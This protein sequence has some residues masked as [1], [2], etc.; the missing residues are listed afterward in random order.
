MFD[1]VN[2]GPQVV[3]VIEE[4]YLPGFFQSSIFEEVLLTLGSDETVQVKSCMS[5]HE[6]ARTLEH[7]IR[8]KMHEWACSDSHRASNMGHTLTSR[9]ARA[10]LCRG[11]SCLIS[12]TQKG[13]HERARHRQWVRID[14][15]VPLSAETGGRACACVHARALASIWEHTCTPAHTHQ[16]LHAPPLPNIF[17][18]SHVQTQM[19]ED[20][21][22]RRSSRCVARSPARLDVPIP[23]LMQARSLVLP[24][25][26]SA[27][28]R[29]DATALLGAQVP[30]SP[31]M[32]AE[33]LYTSIVRMCNRM[34]TSFSV[35][36]TRESHRQ[37]G[38]WLQQGWLMR[39]LVCT[40]ACRHA[41]NSCSRVLVFSGS[42]SKC[43]GCIKEIK[44][45]WHFLNRFFSSAL[46]C[47]PNR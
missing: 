30:L 23:L 47:P 38:K 6:T 21:C 18:K 25:Q 22:A 14:S 34:C 33:F 46:K 27:V 17:D 39:S 7:E 9:R 12:N 37:G 44:Q 5:F 2:H 24:N 40:P 3:N 28:Q 20:A 41:F 1:A 26:L 29:L 43:N 13:A 35:P 31:C 19:H 36:V 15:L 11:R 16:L 45:V 32:N 10:H 4:H 8:T 42:V